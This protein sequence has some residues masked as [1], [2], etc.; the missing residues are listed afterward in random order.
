VERAAKRIG[1]S[2]Q[3]WPTLYASA[4]DLAALDGIDFAEVCIT[5]GVDVHEGEGPAEAFRLP[6]V[7]G[8]AVVPTPAPGDKCQRCWRVLPEV[9]AGLCRRCADAVA[10][11]AA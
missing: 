5:S 6:D 11:V 7:A 10:R 9:H 8:V 1:A 3:A 4:A 2:L